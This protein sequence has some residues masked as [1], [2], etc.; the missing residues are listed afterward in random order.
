MSL[1]VVQAG[2]LVLR[3]PARPLS[4]DE[5]RGKQ[6]QDLIDQMRDTM[7]AASGVGLAAP[8]VGSSI[9]LIVIEDPADGTIASI[10]QDLR[11]AQERNPIPFH[12][13]INPRL[14]VIDETPRLFFEGCLS[15]TGFKA[16]TPRAHA[17]EVEALNEKAEPV[18][19][20]ARGW[21]ARILQH[22]IDH[23]NGM[24]YIDRML[25]RSFMSELVY[26][27][28]WTN[29]TLDDICRSLDVHNTLLRRRQD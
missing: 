9:Q 5:I 6:T 29:A 1:V 17:V 13:L 24:L 19:F 14:R 26:G 23:L 20:D 27:A 2:T 11:A 25:S 21:Y 28:H 16:I 3:Q 22:E 10:P 15:L 18:H 12:V 8:Q 7:R 4:G